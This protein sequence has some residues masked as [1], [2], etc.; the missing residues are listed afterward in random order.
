M[1][2]AIAESRAVELA[3]GF[4]AARR[5]DAG[6]MVAC[7]RNEISREQLGWAVGQLPTEYGAGLAAMAGSLEL[8][9]SHWIVAYEQ[10]G[11]EGRVGTYLNVFDDGRVVLFGQTPLDDEPEDE[12]DE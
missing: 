12:D 8:P 5:L 9:S 3:A 10:V 7:H 6:V 1:A 4:I 2:D 11:P